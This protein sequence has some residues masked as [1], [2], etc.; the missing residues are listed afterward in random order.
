MQLKVLQPPVKTTKREASPGAEPCRPH[1]A[2]GLEQKITKHSP[3][4]IARAQTTRL[5]IGQELGA[6]ASQ[7]TRRDTP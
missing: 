6:E 1:S 3:H 7:K 5:N 4:S 2:K